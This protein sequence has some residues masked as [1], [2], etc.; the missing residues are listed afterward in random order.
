MN[1]RLFALFTVAILIIVLA[2]SVFAVPE[3]VPFNTMV[4]D[5]PGVLTAEE[6]NELNDR[7]WGLT[8]QYECAVYIVINDNLNGMQAWEF[9]EAIHR[10]YKMGYGADKS[11][12][13]LLLS[14]DEREYDIMAHG[15]GNTAFTDYGKEKL[16]DSFLDEFGDDDWYDGFEEYLEGCDEFLKAAREGN[17]V[18]K[19]RSPILGILLGVAFP[20]LVAFIY[21]SRLK[22]QMKTAVMQRAAKVYIGKEGLTLTQKNDRFLHT[23]RTERYIEPQKESKGTTVNSKGNSHKSGKF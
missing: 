9:N 12:I 8:Q 19:G 5:V 3:P 7:A 17:P 16:A 6:A 1:K 2:C 13:I 23:T 10:E 4:V 22:S 14:M 18:D 11:C 15:Y 20:L 21:C